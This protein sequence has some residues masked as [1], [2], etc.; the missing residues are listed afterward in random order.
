MFVGKCFRAFCRMVC[1]QAAEAFF[2][3][4]P[5]AVSFV[6]RIRKPDNRCFVVFE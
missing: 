4:F 1:L 6:V 3:S 5:E 2:E